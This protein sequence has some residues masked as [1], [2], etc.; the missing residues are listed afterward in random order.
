MTDRQTD[1]RNTKKKQNEIY[2]YTRRRDT[3]RQTD[4]QRDT[5]RKGYTQTRHTDIKKDQ[6]KTRITLDYKTCRNLTDAFS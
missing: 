4:R 6:H 2:L 1:G 3:D 5:D